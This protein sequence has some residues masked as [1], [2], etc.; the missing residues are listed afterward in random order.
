[1]KRAEFDPKPV[2]AAKIAACLRDLN[3]DEPRRR[4]EF[5]DVCA[6]NEKKRTVRFFVDGSVIQVERSPL[7]EPYED[8]RPHK[9]GKIHG[10][11]RKSRHR[12]LL[13]VGSLSHAELPLFV[14]LTYPAWW[15]EEWNAWKSHLQTLWKRI[16]YEWPRAS[17]VWKLEP[18]KRGAPHFHL[19]VWGVPFLPK[20]WL[21]QAWFEVVGTKE[22]DHLAAGTSVERARSF[23]GVM[24]YAGKKYLGKEVELPPGW[25][26][27][28][29]FWG[30]LGRKHLPRSRVKEFSVTK[31]AA[32]RFRRLVRRYF[33]SKGKVWKSRNGV[34]LYTQGHL[35]WAR[36]VDWAETGRCQPLDF[37]VPLTCQPF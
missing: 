27:V 28:G 35:Q 22:R 21:A 12:F 17:A 33:A 18:Q 20:E 15:P 2:L 16:G 7:W 8:D 25:D 36:A 11:A 3:K 1:M 9:R 5:A 32:H 23:R 6:A 34:T 24:C 31:Q 10:F 14:T 26:A 19:I 29:R 13:F 30:A 4:G 37:A